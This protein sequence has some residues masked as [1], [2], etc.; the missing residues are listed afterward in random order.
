MEYQGLLRRRIGVEGDAYKVGALIAVFADAGVPEAEIDAFVAGFKPADASFLADDGAKAQSAAAP[1]PRGAV[2]PDGLS[3]SPKAGELARTL[4]VDLSAFAGRS[5]RVSLQDVE[6]AAKAQGLFD[7]PEKSS[8]DNPYTVVKLSAMRR[9]IAKRLTEA[10]ST[11]PHFYLRARISMDALTDLRAQLKKKGAAPTV[12]DYLIK[13][14]A[15]ALMD[16]PEVNVTFAGEELRRYERAD[17]AVAVAAGDG[18]I[19]PVIRRADKKTVAEISAEMQDLAARARA[20]S[21]RQEE[22][23][24]GTFSLSNLGM[25]GVSSFDAVINPP[26]G[27]ILA[28]GAAERAPI[29]GGGY[30]DVMTATLSCDHRVIDGAVGGRFLAALKSALAAPERL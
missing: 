25:Y 17:I 28:A 10:T 27:A 15:K 30:S 4:G 13:A 19:T 20:G 23:R 8:E 3:I 6:Q 7:E 18:L 24:G 12:N 29:E 5:S 16:V 9:T 14:C 22:Y 11:I 26:M 1:P 21:L 2:I